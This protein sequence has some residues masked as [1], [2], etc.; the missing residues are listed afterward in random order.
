MDVEV[1]DA[2]VEM[3]SPQERLALAQRIQA[4]HAEASKLLNEKSY[5]EALKKYKWVFSQKSKP[6]FSL[7]TA[8]IN[9]LMKGYAPAIKVIKRW[10][11]DKEKLIM[12]EKF[13]LS[14]IRDW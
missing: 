2:T 1:P 11:N 7:S 3:T 6:E 9:K 14:L 4:E 13:D 8:E 5:R 10:R 12:A